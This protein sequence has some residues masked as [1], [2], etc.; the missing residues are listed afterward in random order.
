MSREA[1]PPEP[2]VLEYARHYKLSR[3]HLEI[4]PLALVPRPEVASLQLEDESE[5]KLLHLNTC[6]TTPPPERLTAVKEASTLLAITNPIQY[7]ACRLED[8]E[9]IPTHRTR[10][11]TVELPL[12]RSDP[13]ADMLDFV[14]HIEPNLANEF[15]PFEK[16]DDE[17]DE[18]LE[19]PSYC[20][21]WPEIF[22]QKAQN[23][24]IQVAKDVI[25]YLKA[26][27]D[28]SSFKETPGFEHEW[29]SPPRNLV[30]QSVTP[31]LL[32]R[33]PSPQPFEPS[34][35]T[36]HLDLL[37]DHSSPTRQELERINHALVEKDALIPA[38][39]HLDN[40]IAK[41]IAS[42]QSSTN[43][44]ELYSPLEDM[45]VL[46][47]PPRPKRPRAF[48]LKV[49]VPLTPPQSDRPPPWDSRVGS[50]SEALQIIDPAFYL[51]MPEPE[52]N[53]A[54]DIDIL[55][56]EHIAPTAARAEWRIEQEQLQEADTTCRVPV[57]VMDFAKPK[58]PWEISASG[59]VGG[60]Q[61][62]SLFEM[63]KT[64]LNLSQWPLDNRIMRELSWRPF[65]SSLGHFQLEETIEDGGSLAS[66]I[67]EPQAIDLDTLMWKPSRL[68]IF[69]EVN[70]SDEEELE[71]GNFQ[72]TKD[73][74]SLI[75]MRTHEL[76]SGEDDGDILHN[77]EKPGETRIAKLTSRASGI[78]LSQSPSLQRGVPLEN[79]DSPHIA[80]GS[81]FSV[82]NALDD[83]LGMRTGNAQQVQK[84]IKKRPIAIISDTVNERSRTHV[85]VENKMANEPTLP[86]PTPHLQIP[87]T[88][89]FFVAS[90]NFLSNRTLARQV[91]SL[92]PSA[93]MIERDLAMYSLEVTGRG[94][95]TNV[96]RRP[97]EILTDEADLVLSPSTGLI[98]TSIQKIKQ[99]ALP[100][101]A[102]R[103]PIREWIHRVAMRYE[104]LIFVVTRTV[105]TPDK[106]DSCPVG[107]LD[108]S[109]CEALTS[110]M[111][112]S[113]HLPALSDGELLFIDGDIS[114]LATWIVSLM[115]KYSSDNC[116]KL[117]EEETLWEVFL[118][119][120]GM[121]VFAAQAVLAEMK[122]IAGSKG[123]GWGLREFILMSPEERHQRFERCLG[124]RRILE[125]VGKVLDARW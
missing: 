35:E 53:T 63:E 2:S 77:M 86:V 49:E 97:S 43:I 69:D 6:L 27:L 85:S 24:K 74:Q 32:P 90:T 41:S 47:S 54:E 106:D 81:E 124:G 96:C 38:K 62:A 55:L 45:H 31:P 42:A 98:L 14:H 105:I 12:L 70:D 25:A 100:G 123:E 9:L 50:V 4:D 7:Q 73:V 40:D 125:R 87:T 93:R 20:H 59:G 75:K 114:V 80:P 95:K 15:I 110:L 13:E 109:D 113:N 82:I 52:Q 102:T 46:P 64:Q 5:F 57:P 44:G 84:V 89:A 112:F 37:S 17:Q 29:P 104:R 21:A 30:R 121:N 58:P 71:Y 65:P 18:G 117:I 103:Y 56:A 116:I 60:G 88:Q 67:A 115:V 11:F 122:V 83:F 99:Q 16:I 78:Q 19:W 91:Q 33:S 111:A 51:P 79:T 26:T 61:L 101:Q 36:G 8:V 119:Q 92:Y 66:F 22:F 118:R 76:Q 120:A 108:Q 28:L 68:R 10:N 34:S 48:D 72:S 94:T 39:R 1:G 23:E 3:N 107:G